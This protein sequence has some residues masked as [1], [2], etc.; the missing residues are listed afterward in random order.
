MVEHHRS[1]A[2]AELDGGG[3]DHTRRDRILTRPS[4]DV[5]RSGR[6]S[7]GGK[8]H[9]ATGGLDR[10]AIADCQIAVALPANDDEI[11]APA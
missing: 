10:T 5:E 7:G 11:I 4:A 9:R 1:I 8:R 2:I 6:A 3:I